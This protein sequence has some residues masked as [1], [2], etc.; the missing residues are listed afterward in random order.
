MNLCITVTVCQ[1]GINSSKTE[2]R[3]AVYPEGVED[4]GV[5]RQTC[6]DETSKDLHLKRLRMYSCGVSIEV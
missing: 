1:L 5:V 4:M 2:L 6:I 3:R